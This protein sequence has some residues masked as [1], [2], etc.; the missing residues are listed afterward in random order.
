MY[1]I[2]KYN[3]NSIKFIIPFIMSC[4]TKTTK[5]ELYCNLSSKNF[6]LPI[7]VCYNI[8]FGL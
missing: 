6:Y 4:S 3:V 1:I 7:I 8:H 2:N 5:R